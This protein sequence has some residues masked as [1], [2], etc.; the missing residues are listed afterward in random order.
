SPDFLF[1]VEPDADAE[2][3]NA[4]QLAT[5]LSFFLWS[6]VGDSELFSLATD[7]S[8]L[9]P[10]VLAA[11]VKRMLRDPKCERFAQ[12][13][14]EQWLGLNKLGA[15]P[16]GMEEFPDY[17]LF[18]LEPAMKEETWRFFHDLLGRNAPVTHVV[19]ADFTFANEGLCRLY[20]LPPLKGDHLRR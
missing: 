11:E 18:R 17:Y 13:F 7:G 15:M 4:W 12:H 10:D 9:E 6:S 19:D 5:R 8:L 14:T 16:P 1:L 2:Q 20:G 3:L